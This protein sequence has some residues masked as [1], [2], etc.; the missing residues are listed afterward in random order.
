M[1]RLIVSAN[2]I[3]LNNEHINNI[4]KYSF[5]LHDDPT[6]KQKVDKFYF[7]DIN[8]DPH[9]VSRSLIHLMKKETGLYCLAA[10]QLGLDVNCLVFGAE[11]NIVTAFNP[12]ILKFGDKQ[13]VM[14]E[15]NINHMGLSINIKRPITII[16]RYDDVN[17]GENMDVY[18]GITSRLLQQAIDSLNGIQFTERASPIALRRAKKAQ[19]KRQLK[20]VRQNVIKQKI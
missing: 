1:T 18:T 2:D 17:G 3:I 10:N 5:L 15:G 12:E 13:S 19:E 14:L 8:N 11:D 9:Q 6:L 7:T 16:M 4:D 20:F